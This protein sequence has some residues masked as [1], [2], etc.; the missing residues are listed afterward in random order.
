MDIIQDISFVWFLIIFLGALVQGA[1]GFGFALVVTPLMVM[2]MEVEALIVLVITLSFFTSALMSWKLRRYAEWGLIKYLL[3]SSIVGSALGSYLLK[4]WGPHDLP[5]LIIAVFVILFSLLI[6]FEVS[7]PIEKEE[8]GGMVAGF[9]SGV[10]TTLTSFGGP[11]VV[12]LLSNQKKLPLYF[13]GTISLYFFIKSFFSILLLIVITGVRPDIVLVSTIFIPFVLLGWRA[14][15]LLANRISVKHFRLA[16][17]FIIMTA[18]LRI[19]V[20]YFAWA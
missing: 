8:V 2:F 1:T 13:K 16:V 10:F 3:A 20:N 9:F 5:K 6:Y 7:K 19:I 17:L 14:G 18:A 11:P 15:F 4:V 12:L